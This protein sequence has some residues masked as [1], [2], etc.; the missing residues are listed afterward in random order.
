MLSQLRKVR[1]GLLF[2]ML[3]AV[4]WSVLSLWLAFDGHQPSGP[5]LFEKQY[6]TQALLT[7]PV[8]L[9]SWFVF[10]RVVWQLLANHRPTHSIRRWQNHLGSI[11]G[12]GYL[13]CWLL[14]DIVVYA[15]CDFETLS[16]VA[17]FLPILTTVVVV[18]F[19]TRFVCREVAI[20]RF[21]A[22]LCV[23]AAWIVQSI[24]ILVFI[25]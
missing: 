10:S 3:S 18:F 6:Q 5:S 20:R 4:I 7:I 13:C 9:V 19:A 24:P 17:P 8:L 1:R 14:P 23:L 21:P 25:R 16:Q 12:I 22:M 15:L 2:V 11:L